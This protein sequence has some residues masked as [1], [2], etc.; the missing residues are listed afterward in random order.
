MDEDENPENKIGVYLL[1]NQQTDQG[2]VGSSVDIEERGK[3]HF[4]LLRTGKHPNRRL[5]AAY[6]A[7]PN[8]DFVGLVLGDRDAAFDYEQSVID[9]L[10]KSPVLLNISQDARYCSVPGLKHSD[11]TKAK[12]GAASKGNQYRLGHK[13]SDFQ[14]EQLRKANVGRPVSEE[15]RAKI[16]QANTGRIHTEEANEKNRQAH[17]GKMISDQ[18]KLKMSQAKKGMAISEEAKAKMR[19]ARTGE[20]KS[21]SADGVT[22]PSINEAARQLGMNPGTVYNRLNSPSFPMWFFVTA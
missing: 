7:N 16:S 3:E 11:E 8:F 14:K 18:T 19:E 15:T 12:I 22:Y 21:V 5:Q 4:Q 13:L 20:F 2:Y 6:V 1:H 10:G 9:E 17:L